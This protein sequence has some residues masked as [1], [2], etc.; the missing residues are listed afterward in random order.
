MPDPDSQFERFVEAVVHGAVFEVA[1]HDD[2]VGEMFGANHAHPILYQISYV[3]KGRS[4]VLIGKRRYGAG[5]G[6]LM[7]IPPGHLHGSK[8]RDGDERF[9]L[10]QIKFSLPHCP[11]WPLPMYMHVGRPTILSS[12]FHSIISEFHMRRP[13]RELI[14]RLDLARLILFLVRQRRMES[15][16]ARSGLRPYPVR[17]ESSVKKVIRHITANYSRNLPLRELAGIAGYS[18]GRFGHL[19][20]SYTGTS[21]VQYVIN[22]RLSK[23]LEM[24]THSDRK[25]AD[26]ASEAGFS[27]AYYFSRLFHKRYQQ[28]P[29]RYARRVYNAH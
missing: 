23:A 9:E 19:F 17:V 16:G 15:E 28:S 12:L 5:E 20:Q 18:V 22:Y 7:L 6:D 4:R 2:Y 29:R 25:L 26:I 3:V 11:F 13:Q 24:M 14:M 10:L 21:P 27:S 1:D 8:E